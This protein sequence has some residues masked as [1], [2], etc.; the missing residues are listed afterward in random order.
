VQK[1]MRADL[2]CPA[3][4]GAQLRQDNSASTTSPMAAQLNNTLETVA[5]TALATDEL[6]YQ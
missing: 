4:A 1:L 5:A 2:I 6:W 3:Y